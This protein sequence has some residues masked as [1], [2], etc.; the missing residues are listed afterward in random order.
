MGITWKDAVTTVLA[1]G[2]ITVAVAVVQKWGTPILSSARL[3]SVIILAVGVGMCILSGY[4]PEKLNSTY[5]G[6]M[7]MIAGLAGIAAILGVVFG[8]GF[9][10]VI[11]AGAVGILWLVST[12]RHFIS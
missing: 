1:A 9:F 2:V 3:A 5:A 11:A 8:T 10:V 7:S 12:I 6:L 4:D